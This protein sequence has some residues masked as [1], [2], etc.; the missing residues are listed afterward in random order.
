V[1]LCCP[2]LFVGIVF[3][4]FVRVEFDCLCVEMCCLCRPTRSS[5][6][7]WWWC[8]RT[9]P[10]RTILP[11]RGSLPTPR[12]ADRVLPSKKKKEKR[13]NT[14]L[15]PAIMLQGNISS[16]SFFQQIICFILLPILFNTFLSSNKSLHV[17]FF[18]QS[19][20]SS[21]GRSR[22]W[23]HRSRCQRRNGSCRN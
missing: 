12:L 16:S 7:A 13:V 14:F 18:L 8:T 22:I 6:R 5:E 1:W 2:V 4:C 15:L 20:S 3:V 19:S 21:L 9:W 11:C 17:S 10:R 23:Q